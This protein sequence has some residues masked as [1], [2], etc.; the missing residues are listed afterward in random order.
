MKLSPL[1]RRACAW[2]AVILLLV[3]TW[4]GISGGV[5]QWSDPATIW[6]RVQ[7]AAQAVYGFFAL[8]M[9]VTAIRWQ[10]FKPL[11]EGGFIVGCAIAAGFAAVVWGAQSV[12]AGIATGAGTAMIAIV[13]AWMLRIGVGSQ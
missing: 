9:L 5:S 7:V 11:A 4:E 3:L 1:L 6:E 8:F 13:I 10:Q 12:R 2:I